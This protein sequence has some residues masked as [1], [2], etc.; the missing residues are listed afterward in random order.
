MTKIH[1]TL[2]VSNAKKINSSFLIDN[3]HFVVNMTSKVYNFPNCV[4]RCNLLVPRGHI[5]HLQRR[6]KLKHLTEGAVMTT[7]RGN[8]NFRQ[9]VQRMSLDERLVLMGVL[10]GKITRIVSYEIMLRHGFRGVKPAQIGEIREYASQL[11][12]I[13]STIPSQDEDVHNA[14]ARSWEFRNFHRE[15]VYNLGHR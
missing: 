15:V 11:R 13:L 14:S 12:T 1:N 3:Y 5:A 4:L 8:S 6:V 9:R 2:F 7:R 10:R